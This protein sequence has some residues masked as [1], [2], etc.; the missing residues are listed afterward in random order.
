MTRELCADCG[1]EEVE[2]FEDYEGGHY[3][4]RCR[5][6]ND[7]LIARANERQEWNYYH[8]AKGEVG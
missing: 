8:S 7:K 5:H 6:C 4:S 2:F 1:V 3:D